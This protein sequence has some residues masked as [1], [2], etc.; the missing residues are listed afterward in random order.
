MALDSSFLLKRNI[1]API[2]GSLER[3]APVDTSELW[4]QKRPPTGISQ[5]KPSPILALVRKGKGDRDVL[6]RPSSVETEG[7]RSDWPHFHYPFLLPLPQQV[8]AEEVPP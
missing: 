6:M 5:I 4:P 7:S 8:N 2:N 1:V 3:S